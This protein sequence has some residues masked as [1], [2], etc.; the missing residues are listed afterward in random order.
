[1]TYIAPIRRKIE[2]W[3]WYEENMPKSNYWGNQPEHDAFRRKYDLD[4]VLTN[5]NLYAD[6]LFSLWRPFRFTLVRMHGYDV[7]KKYGNINQ[8]INFV[9]AIME[10]DNLEKLLP[11][12]EPIVKKLS[13]LFE[14]GQGRENVFILPDR[15]LNTERAQAPFWDYMPAFLA[16]SFAGGAFSKYWSG[17]EQY[18]KWLIEQDLIVFFEGVLVSENIKDL[19]GSGDVRNGLP[20]DGIEAMERMIDNYIEILELRKTLL[21]KWKSFG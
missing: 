20:P 1:M 7:L 14:L 6:T 16:E 5:G 11:N 18:K 10:G 9:R 17:E 21:N 13:Y 4:C 8:K 19:S 12:K 2:S 3:I 15:S